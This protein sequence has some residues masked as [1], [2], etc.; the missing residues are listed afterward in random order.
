MDDEWS[1][2]ILA[3]CQIYHVDVVTEWTDGSSYKVEEIISTECPLSLLTFWTHGVGLGVI[4]ILSSLGFIILT[5]AGVGV[6][7]YRIR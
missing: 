5:I 7:Y 4:I 6:Y 2:L 1:Y 3:S